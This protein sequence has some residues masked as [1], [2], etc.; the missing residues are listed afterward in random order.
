VVKRKDRVRFAA[1]KRSLQADNGIA[2]LSSEP[3]DGALQ[4]LAQSTCHERDAKELARVAVGIDPFIAGNRR[5]VG[6]E[7]R[8]DKAGGHYVGVGRGDITPGFPSV[9]ASPRSWARLAH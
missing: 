3:L 6:C 2:A 5:E 1:A 8:L 9:P 4:N 7:L